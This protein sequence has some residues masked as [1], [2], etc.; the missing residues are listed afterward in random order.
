[1][2]TVNIVFWYKDSWK[3]R[4]LIIITNLLEETVLLAFEHHFSFDGL[5]FVDIS[6]NCGA[7]IFIYNSYLTITNSHDQEN[8]TIITQNWVAIKISNKTINLLLLF[9]GLE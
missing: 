1:M 9:R 8:T 7:Y 2:R 3:E 4:F 5:C 6:R